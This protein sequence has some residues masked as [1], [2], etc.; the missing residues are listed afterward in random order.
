MATPLASPAEDE[1]RWVE[2]QFTQWRQRRITP[3][4]R[5]PQALWD[6]AIALTR[7][8]P[9]A[10]GAQQLGLCPQRLR[11]R[12][13]EQAAA[14]VASVSAPPP[15]VEVT[16]AWRSPTAEV[17]GQRPDGT[18]LHL[19]SHGAAPALVPLLHPFLGVRCCCNSRRRALSF[20]PCRPSTAAKAVTASRRCAAR[21]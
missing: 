3:R 6:Q 20:S 18:R 13:R 9:L 14:G 2:Q 16:P 11:K 19:T 10:R 21:R 4:G 7:A 1:L 8:V 17:E 15:F 12:S 5:I